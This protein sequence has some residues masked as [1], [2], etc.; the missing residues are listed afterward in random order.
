MQ[1]THIR[2]DRSTNWLHE[3]PSNPL[4]LCR[5]ISRKWEPACPIE[6]S[7]DDKHPE[8][9]AKEEQI[10]VVETRKVFVAC[11]S[12]ALVSLVAAAMFPPAF[13]FLSFLPTLRYVDLMMMRDVVI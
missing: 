11:Q 10:R 3:T 6:M 12:V 2:E 4:S 13:P 8:N 9:R 7:T 1:E 5:R